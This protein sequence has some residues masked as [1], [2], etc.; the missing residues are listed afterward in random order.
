MNDFSWV[1]GVT[2][3]IASVGAVLGVINTW[4]ALRKSRVRMSVKARNAYTVGH[5]DPR[6]QF[7]IEVTN[8]S[9]FPITVSEVGFQYH[10]TNERRSIINPILA[11]DGKFPRR[12]ESRQSVSFYMTRPTREDGGRMLKGAFASTAC[13]KRVDVPI[14]HDW[15]D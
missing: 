12:L 11:D 14:P 3:F 9:E 4:H 2:L 1:D 15:L 6:I 5:V 13:G 7:A 8:L 10:G